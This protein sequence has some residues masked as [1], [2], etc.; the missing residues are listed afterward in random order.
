MLQSLREA[1]LDIEVRMLRKAM[2]ISLFPRSPVLLENGRFLSPL[3]GDPQGALDQCDGLYCYV[4]HYGTEIQEDNRSRPHQL[5]RGRTFLIFAAD[6]T[7][8][9]VHHHGRQSLGCCVAT[10]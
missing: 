8:D 7:M 5:L 4:A 3:F 1:G 2:E 6:I 9:D 10:I